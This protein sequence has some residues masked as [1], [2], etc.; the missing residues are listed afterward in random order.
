MELSHTP[1]QNRNQRLHATAQFI[2]IFHWV[3]A[4]KNPRLHLAI[5][6]KNQVTI[7]EQNLVINLT[8]KSVI[9][10]FSNLKITNVNHISIV[11]TK[12][13]QHAILDS[14]ITAM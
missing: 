3:T 8:K 7:K 1:G 2:H 12:L 9:V 4:T 11:L 5:E 10:K 14:K 13:E 6:K